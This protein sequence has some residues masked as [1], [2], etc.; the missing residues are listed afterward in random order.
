MTE[1]RL[2]LDAETSEELE[3]ILFAITD[4]QIPLFGSER[5][6]SLHKRCGVLIQSIRSGK[7]DADEN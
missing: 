7:F 6:E 5:L 3:S 4:E 2:L 1:K